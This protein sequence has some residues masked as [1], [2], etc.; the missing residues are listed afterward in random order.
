MRNLCAVFSIILPLFGLYLMFAVNFMRCF[1]AIDSKKAPK[2][3]AFCFLV[4]LMGFEPVNYHAISCFLLPRVQFRVQFF[5]NSGKDRL[6][7]TP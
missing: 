6:S 2:T 7:Q 3:G 1:F 4:R 5:V